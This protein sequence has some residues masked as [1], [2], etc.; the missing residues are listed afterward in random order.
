MLEHVPQQVTS[1]FLFFHSAGQSSAQ[2]QAFLPQWSAAL[3]TTY[4]WAGDGPISGSPLMRQNLNY[5]GEA[6]R[7][8]FTFP[9]QD[10]CSPESFAAHTEAM[11]ATLSCAGAYV[12]ALADQ[13]IA[14]FGLSVGQIVLCGFQ[15]GGCV[16][17]TAAMMR[18]HDPYKIAVVF[19]PYIL[20]SY[21]LKDEHALAPTT[22]VCIDNQHIRSRTLNWIH[23]ETDKAFQAYGI[24]TRGITVPEGGDDLDSAMMQAAIEVMRDV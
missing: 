14:R 17:L 19:E 1:A 4:L 13:V 11:G 21:Y 16:A 9:M 20:E 7:Y 3:P 12:N 8:W 24:A 22:V 23:V 6:N 5:G 10:A 15:H 18:R 2:F